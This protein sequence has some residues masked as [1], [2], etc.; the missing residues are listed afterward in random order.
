MQ[1]FESWKELIRPNVKVVQTDIHI[2]GHS[3][4]TFRAFFT[5][6]L[7]LQP[8]QVSAYISSQFIHLH[9]VIKSFNSEKLKKYAFAAKNSW[10]RVEIKYVPRKGSICNGFTFQGV[11][12]NSDELARI[13]GQAF[14]R[15]A[16]LATCILYIFANVRSFRGQSLLML[17][18]GRK[19]FGG[20]IKNFDLQMGVAKIK[21]T[22]R[23]AIK[24]ISQTVIYIF[25][26]ILQ[27]YIRHML[28]LRFANNTSPLDCCKWA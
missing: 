8:L 3:S 11:H 16:S 27:C 6:Q 21:V 22:K 25:C 28:H 12:I 2:D 18:K 7:R 26:N 9:N 15:N 13:R 19:I 5:S 20:L 10:K 17:G 24:V 1:R 4:I 23:W 14:L